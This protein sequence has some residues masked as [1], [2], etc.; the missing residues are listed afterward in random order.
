MTLRLEA[1][2]AAHVVVGVFAAIVLL[3]LEDDAPWLRRLRR[4]VARGWIAACQRSMDSAHRFSAA[5]IQLQGKELFRP[6]GWRM[7]HEGPNAL[8]HTRRRRCRLSAIQL[9]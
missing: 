3:V 4:P 1:G 7:S 5:V 2:S 8:H 9:V 6:A